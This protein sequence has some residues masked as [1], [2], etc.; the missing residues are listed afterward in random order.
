MTS[1]P[2]A[3]RN[4]PRLPFR[5][6][7]VVPLYEYG[8]VW[9]LQDSPYDYCRTSRTIVNGTS[10]TS[11]F[12]SFYTP[13]PKPVSTHVATPFFTRSYIPST[14]HY[15][16]TIVGFD[17]TSVNFQQGHL[18]AEH[19]RFRLNANFK[20]DWY[21]WEFPFDKQISAYQGTTENDTGYPIPIDDV[22]MDPIPSPEI[23]WGQLPIYFDMVIGNASVSYLTPSP[24]WERNEILAR[25]QVIQRLAE[26]DVNLSVFAAE[27]PQSIQW[28]GT[29]GYRLV[30][31][32]TA[33]L[34]FDL[35]GAI[36]ALRIKTTRRQRRLMETGKLVNWDDF[37]LEFNYA[38]IPL[39]SDIYG[40]IDALVSGLR[41]E[42]ELI[43]VRGSS[44]DDPLKDFVSWQRNGPKRSWGHNFMQPAA[45]DPTLQSC[46]G[47]AYSLTFRVSNPTLRSLQEL[48][49]INP[50]DA[51][52]EKTP[53]SFLIDWL[54]NLNVILQSTSAGAGVTFVDG[55]RSIYTLRPVGYTDVHQ[56]DIRANLK[57]LANNM[58]GDHDEDD[59]RAIVPSRTGYFLEADRTVVES[60]D[61]DIPVHNIVSRTNPFSSNQRIANFIALLSKALKQ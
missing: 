25:S 3:K 6:N 8:Q 39:M 37:I 18:A 5:D 41:T 60:F 17:V 23:L 47:V 34:R 31:F 19:Y 11:S 44:F 24:N 21:Q 42:G 57:E 52:W 29:M 28:L 4:S 48:G 36:R 13:R 7:G 35:P 49:L 12:E 22:A 40:M 1:L 14:D 56:S 27:L 30:Q 55:S 54:I 38:F 59:F 33:I 16:R 51:V 45:L 26:G 58:V 2:S 46:S 20:F 32:V 43:H 61:T 53:F 15:D 9:L 10:T 50:L